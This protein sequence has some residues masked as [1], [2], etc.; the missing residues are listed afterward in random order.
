MP[1]VLNVSLCCFRSMM[2]SM[3]VMPMSRM[4]VMSRLFMVAGFMM[5]RGLLMVLRCVLVVLRRLAV[6]FCCCL[7][8]C[9][10]SFWAVRGPHKQSIRLRLSGERRMNLQGHLFPGHEDEMKIV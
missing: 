6:V 5:L 1:V 7:R 4:R 2:E 9:A 8:H 10:A 3:D